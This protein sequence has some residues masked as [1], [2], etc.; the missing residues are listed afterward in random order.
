MGEKRSMATTDDKEEEAVAD[1]IK[2]DVTKLLKERIPLMAEL[3]EDE[4]EDEA[5]LIEKK[6]QQEEPYNKNTHNSVLVLYHVWSAQS[7]ENRDT[8]FYVTYRIDRNTTIEGLHADACKYWGCSTQEY[9]LCRGSTYSLLQDKSSDTRVQDHDILP[10]NE[11]AMLHLVK[12]QDWSSWM[13]MMKEEDKRKKIEKPGEQTASAP[14]AD[15]AN[16]T[17]SKAATDGNARMEPWL[18][19]FKEWPGLHYLLV[20]R[21]CRFPPDLRGGLLPI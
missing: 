8:E 14:T 3:E 16:K 2:T 20:K 19:S 11:M 7:T 13:Q 4:D 17:A 12:R 18:N 1:F 10:P 15:Q 5:P 6:E 21:E 9:C